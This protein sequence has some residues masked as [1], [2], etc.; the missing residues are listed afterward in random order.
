MNPKPILIDLPETIETSRLI[1]KMP[2][3][4]Y[5][6]EVHEA[7]IDGYEDYIKW[8]NWPTALPTLESVEEDCR[9][10]H[11]EF[12]TREFIRYVIFEKETM[13]VVGR[14][15]YPSFQTVWP[16]PQFGISYFI[17]KSS[18]N[19]GYAT[20]TAHAL[21]VLAFQILGAKKVEIYCD[22]ENIESQKVPQKLG[23]IL[24][25]TKKGG[26]PR[27]DNQLAD[28]LTFSIFSEASLPKWDVTY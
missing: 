13:R 26:W 5:G 4:G 3:A 12:I 16:I 23:Y 18:R 10:Q 14:S 20:E 19:K 27:P 24:E 6:S 22:G 8:L 17:R 9:K 28:L 15:A 2:R 7:I 1:L 21:T 25:C 11:A